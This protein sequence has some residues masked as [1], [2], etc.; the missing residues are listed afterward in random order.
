MVDPFVHSAQFSI[1]CL[2]CCSLNFY[3]SI[4]R[5]DIQ[6][7]RFL[8]YDLSIEFDTQSISNTIVN[9][10]PIS[11]RFSGSLRSTIPQGLWL[12]D[13]QPVPNLVLRPTPINLLSD[14]ATATYSSTSPSSSMSHASP[15][16]S[17]FSFPK[18]SFFWSLRHISSTSLLS[19]WPSIQSVDALH[20]IGR[21][22]FHTSTSIT[23]RSPLHW[24]L[25]SWDFYSSSI[26]DL[27][28]FLLDSDWIHCWATT[29]IK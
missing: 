19:R 28:V 24:D 16:T 6:T 14:F 4:L 9:L 27:L 12:I 22:K 23:H 11:V 15:W 13:T 1:N 21:Q 5:S 29:T 7:Y 25:A 3:D 2:R 17:L 26:G 20:S 18:T 8:H 10:L